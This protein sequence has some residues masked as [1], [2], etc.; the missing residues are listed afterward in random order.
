LEPFRD[1]QLSL[2]GEKY[3]RSSYIVPHI[4]TCRVSLEDGKG[5]DQPE[6]ICEL[7]KTMSVDFNVR[8]GSVNDRIF[9]TG[10]VVRGYL[11]RQEGMHPAFVIS[12][13]L[14][15]SFKGLDGM[16]VNLASKRCLDDYVWDLMIDATVAGGDGSDDDSSG[17]GN[18]EAVVVEGEENAI[19]TRIMQE[20]VLLEH[21]SD[22]VLSENDIRQECKEELWAG[23]R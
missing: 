16:G 6:C 14:H 11:S 5:P 21:E 8:W 23:S 19:I 12:T 3:V 1:A 13:F 4:Y 17:D 9:D 18:Q 22:S 20:N 15:P 2:E 7:S 10:I